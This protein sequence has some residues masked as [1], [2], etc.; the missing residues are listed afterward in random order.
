MTTITCEHLLER[1]DELLDGTLDGAEA[2]ALE[3]HLEQCPECRLELESSRLLESAARS[4]PRSIEPDRDLWPGSS[5]SVSRL[6]VAAA[7]A[8]VVVAAVTAAYLAGLHRGAP[9][10]AEM[11]SAPSP[12]A[13]SASFELGGDLVRV[14]DELMARLERRQDEL[15]PE[16]WMVVRDNLEV[17]DRAISRIAV[18]LDEHPNDSRLNHRLAVA[19]R[20]EIDLLQR[21]TRL[22]AES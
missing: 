2:A 20:Q 14:R 11:I 13:V 17:I 22:P 9:R 12:G 10:T 5:W 16:T 18:A 3:S 19:Y 15:S 1:V 7:A 6:A 4:L 21:A 8:A